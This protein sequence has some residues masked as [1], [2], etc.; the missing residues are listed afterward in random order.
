MYSRWYYLRY[1][2]SYSASN[3]QQQHY[4]SPNT[5]EIVLK[6]INALHSGMILLWI[7]VPVSLFKLA[8]WTMCA[9]TVVH[10]NSMEKHLQCVVLMVKSNCNHQNH[11]R[12]YSPEWQTNR[13]IFV[14]HSKIQIKARLIK[15][16]LLNQYKTINP[17]LH[18]FLIYLLKHQL[19]NQTNTVIN[20]FC[21]NF[22]F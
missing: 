9:S 17:Y 21:F 4:S 13:S 1:S 19:L 7:I 14:Q 6:I 2:Y 12:I 5:R 3:T 10:C 20:Y 8:P 18:L 15:V 11:W 22:N 16:N